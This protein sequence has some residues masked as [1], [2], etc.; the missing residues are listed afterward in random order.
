VFVGDNYNDVAAMRAA[1]LGIAFNCKSEELAQVA[2]VV[3]AGRDLR[4]ILKYVAG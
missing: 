3:V 4:E 2:D 1:G